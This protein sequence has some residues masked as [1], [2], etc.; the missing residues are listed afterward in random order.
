MEKLLIKKKCFSFINHE[1][2]SITLRY[3]FTLPLVRLYSQIRILLVLVY[4]ILEKY[5]EKKNGI[6]VV[7]RK[8]IRLVLNFLVNQ[9]I[10]SELEILSLALQVIEQLGLNKT[11]FEIGSAK[12]FQRLCHLADGSTELLTE[13]LLKKDLSGLNAFI[14]KNSFSKELRELL[15]E[16]FITNEL[17]RLENLVTNTKDDVLISSFDQLKEFSEKLSMIKPIIID[18]EWF[19]KWIIY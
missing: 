15:K 13:L 19:L 1:G 8:I 7:Q 3:D 4:H 10:E 9:P 18:L 2:Q 5:L 14:E 17:S 16:I 11:V 12:F 6:K